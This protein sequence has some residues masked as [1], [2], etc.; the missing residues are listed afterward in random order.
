MVLHRHGVRQRPDACKLLQP[1]VALPVQRVITIFKQL[2]MALAT[3][4]KKGSYT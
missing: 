2:L 1:E 4:T 3:R